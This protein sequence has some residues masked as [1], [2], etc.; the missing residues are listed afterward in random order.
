[1]IISLERIM[2]AV[3]PLQENNTQKMVVLRHLYEK[4]INQNGRSEQ[5]FSFSLQ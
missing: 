2:I 5:I 1:M 4:N 3:K